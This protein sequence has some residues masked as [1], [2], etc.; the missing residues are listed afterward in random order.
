MCPSPLKIC[1]QHKSQGGEILTNTCYLVGGFKKVESLEHSQS[2]M[3]LNVTFY[4]IL[5]FL[6]MLE[7][8][9]ALSYRRIWRR[10]YKRR[11]PFWAMG[12]MWVTC[13]ILALGRLLWTQCSKCNDW[14]L[15][16]SSKCLSQKVFSWEAR[17]VNLRFTLSQTVT[18]V[19]LKSYHL[20]RI[21]PLVLT[22]APPHRAERG[23]GKWADLWVPPFEHLFLEFKL[24]WKSLHC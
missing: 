2:S 12:V 18:Q 1:A 5:L 13:W 21:S 11:A 24:H 3:D 10:S 8:Q 16:I 23:L 7:R 4:K 19:T 20:W 15:V 9:K 17:M 22:P 14:Q 6:M